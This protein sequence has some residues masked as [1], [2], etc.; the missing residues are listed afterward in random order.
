MSE[1]AAVKWPLSTRKEVVPSYLN[2][3]FAEW[4]IVLLIR[5]LMNKIPVLFPL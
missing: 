3:S 5:Y 4:A 1:I 2:G